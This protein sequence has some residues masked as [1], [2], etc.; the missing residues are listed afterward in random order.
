V[1]ALCRAHGGG[2]RCRDPDCN[3]GAKGATLFCVTHGGGKRCLYPAGCTK[4]AEAATSFCCAH[5]GGK[6]CKYHRGCNK[7][8]RKGGMCKE[9]AVEAGRW[10]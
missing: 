8:V 10:K 6:R 7:H 2:K 1:T 9:H 3:K 4:G 5:G